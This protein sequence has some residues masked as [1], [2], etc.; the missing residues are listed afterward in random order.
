MAYELILGDC[1]DVMQAMPTNFVKMTFTSPPYADAR[2]YGINF[3]MTGQQW[4]DWCFTRILEMCRVTDGLVFF[5]AAGR[6]EDFQYQPIMEWLV[7]DLTR[8]TGGAIVCGPAPYVFHRVGIPGSGGPHYHR[9]DWEP[10]YCFA[11]EGSLPLKWSD[12]TATGHP[13][14]WAPGGEMSARLTNGTRVNQ[15]GKPGSNTGT[16][17]TGNKEKE[18]IGKPRPSHQTTSKKAMATCGHKDG[19]TQTGEGYDPPAIANSG[20]KIMQTYTAAEVDAIVGEVN[21]VLLLKV[22]GGQMGS[23]IAHESEAPFPEELVRFFVVS[24]CPPGGR[25]LDPFCG[26]GTTISVAVQENRIGVGIDIRDGVGGLA[27][28]RKRLGTV[29]P[30]GLFQ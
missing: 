3:K 5:N 30:A 17:A 10:V 2:T 12:N 28:A 14:K 26:S 11:K 27:S 24:Y 20:N 19:D 16:V 9:R 8:K 1:L 29:T 7:A 18:A 22:G 4:V 25:V 13:P 6:V 21:D 15:W 23:P